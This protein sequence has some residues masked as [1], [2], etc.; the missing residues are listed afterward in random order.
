MLKEN[1]RMRWGR[2]RAEKPDEIIP[3]QLKAK[4]DAQLR[5]LAIELS[6][7]G[8]DPDLMI[9]KQ[10]FDETAGQHKYS[11]SY[12]RAILLDWMGVER[13]RSH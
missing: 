12:V 2:V 6:G 1:Y 11:V 4:D 10:A 8:C 3:R 13:N 5:D 7:A 9:L